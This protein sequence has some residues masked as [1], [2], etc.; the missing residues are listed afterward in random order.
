LKK[1]NLPRSIGGFFSLRAKLLIITSLAVSIFIISC[2]EEGLIGLDILDNRAG[3]GRIDTLNIIAISQQEDSVPT[4]NVGRGVLGV[5]NDPAFGKARSSIYTEFRLFE[6]N[7]SLGSNPFV[8]SVVV[9]L[10]YFGF[11]GDSLTRQNIKVYELLENIPSDSIIYSNRQLEHNA[12]PIGEKRLFHSP[13]DSTMVGDVRI[14]ASIRIKLSDYFVAKLASYNGTSTFENNANFLE[15]FKGLYITVEDHNETGGMAYIDLV[16][17]I[18]NV[19]LYYINQDNNTAV[20][21]FPINQFCLRYNYFENFGYANTIPILQ[22][23]ILEGNTLLGDSLLFLQGLQGVRIA[24]SIPELSTFDEDFSSLVIN[25][26]TL[27]LPVDDSFNHEYFTPPSRL[28]L[29]AV[30]ESDE[31]QSIIDSQLGNVLYGGDYNAAKK[32]YEFNITRHIQA[33][34][35]G[36]YPTSR[37]VL[38]GSNPIENAHRIVLKG[39]GRAEDKMRI[40]ITY[41]VFN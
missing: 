4:N 35:S 31:F 5:I 33:V 24:F 38:R 18:T 25:K 29:L 16:N 39:P 2:E 13:N 15:V 10:K 1:N 26:A 30:N 17:A 11:Y 27:I 12:I 7:I 9:T 37:F 22:Q 19:S 32:R 14:P 28:M 20:Q 36:I 3:V 6:N 34:V 41:S 8:D 23:Q 21:V 40:E